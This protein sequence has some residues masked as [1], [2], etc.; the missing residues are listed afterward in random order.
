MKI[1]DNYNPRTNCNKPTTLI[2]KNVMGSRDKSGNFPD[3]VDEDGK[4]FEIYVLGI[5]SDAAKNAIADRAREVEKLKNDLKKDEKISD[6]VLADIGRSYIA[7]LITGWSDNF[8]D[9]TGKTLKF[10]HANAVAL[11]ESEDWIADQ[12]HETSM[13]LKNY[14]PNA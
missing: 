7:S 8:K 3:C 11:L 4:N 14:D 9:D 12:V 5:K 13:N 2:L 1:F 6:E 10:S